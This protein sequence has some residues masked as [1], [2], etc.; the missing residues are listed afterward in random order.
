MACITA[1]AKES[2]EFVKSQE[3][4]LNT[5]IA[6]EKEDQDTV[7]LLLMTNYYR[8]RTYALVLFRYESYTY[9]GTKEH[10]TCLVIRR[11]AR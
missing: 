1:D 3:A 11:R 2:Q 8:R 10:H 6:A 9:H 7:L 4:E 5:K